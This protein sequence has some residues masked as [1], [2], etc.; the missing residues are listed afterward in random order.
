[1]HIIEKLGSVPTTKGL[2]ASASGLR[3]ARGK[4]M[5]LAVRA[6]SAE[7]STVNAL[8]KEL[9]AFIQ[10]NRGLKLHVLVDIPPGFLAA[11]VTN[12][13]REGQKVTLHG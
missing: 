7:Q 5:A 8:T 4:A 9:E 12:D 1:M 10:A 2:A 3:V 11:I 6:L 13:E